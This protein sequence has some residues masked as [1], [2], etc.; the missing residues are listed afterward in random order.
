[1]ACTTSSFDELFMQPH[2]F[3]MAGGV[4]GLAVGIALSFYF[5]PKIEAG[6]AN[7]ATGKMIIIACAAAGAFIGA[8]TKMLWEH[9]C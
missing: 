5:R 6:E 3:A 9:F 2:S 1:M 8:V 4:A 7:R